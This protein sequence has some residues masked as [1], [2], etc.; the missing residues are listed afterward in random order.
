MTHRIHRI[1][2][3]VRP[4]DSISASWLL[5]RCAVS[6]LP[7]AAQT[8]EEAKKMST[9]ARIFLDAAQLPRRSGLTSRCNAFTRAASQAQ[10]RFSLSIGAAVPGGWRSLGPTESR[11]GQRVLRFRPM[12]DA[13]SRDRCC[14]GVP[15]GGKLFIGTASGGVWQSLSGGYWLPDRQPMQSEHWSGYDRRGRPERHLRGNGEYNTNSWG[16]GI[17]VLPDGERTGH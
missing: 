11:C 2:R 10:A 15:L 3:S 9:R 7:L 5:P 1:A 17:L 16:C 13:G 8:T 6:A 4:S 14:A 12:L